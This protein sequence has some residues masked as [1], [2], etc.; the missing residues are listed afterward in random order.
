MVIF[1]QLKEYI[2]EHRI[3]SD[4]SMGTYYS[5]L[6]NQT[7]AV[8]EFANLS[9]PEIIEQIH[10]EY[11]QAGARI[12]RTNT[13]AANTVVLKE[14]ENRIR[15]I[16]EAGCK[17]AK[18][19]VG[20]FYDSMEPKERVWILGNIG[21]IPEE[22]DRKEKDILKEY[23]RICDIFIEE[24]LDG[25]HFETF[26]GLRYIEKLVPYIKERNQDMFILSSFSVDKNG[27]CAEGIGASRLLDMVS[28]IDGID[29][30]GLNCGVGSGHMVQI[31]K[32]LSIPENKII[33]IAPNAGYPEQMHNRMVFMDNARYFAENMRIIAQQG[34]DIIGSCCG[35]SPQYTKKL[36]EYI[37]LDEPARK[38][39]DQRRMEL[40]K[41]SPIKENDFI[42]KL[43]KNQKVIA[44]ELDPPYNAD[45]QKIMECAHKLKALGADVITIADSP[46]GRSRVDSVLM[47]VKIA[48]E[49]NIP[50]MPHICCRDRNM[51]SM[52]SVIL[53]AYIHGIRN[54]LLVTGDPIPGESRQS[55]TGVF[56]YNSIRLMNFVKEMNLEHFSTDSLSYGGAL[57]YNRG[58]IDKV[59]DRMKRKMEAGAGFFLTQPVY[60]EE[61]A[62]R[63]KE[64]KERVDTKIICG[65]MP[66]VSYRNASFIKNEITGIHI[67]DDILNRY[68]PD[69][70]K[71]E[72]E[73]VGAA[74][75]REVMEMVEPF[76]DGYYFMLPFNRVSL[77]DK[78]I[79]Y[80]FD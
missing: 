64:I 27:Y 6:V 24:K 3:I 48:Q 31:V 69:M 44:V 4:G 23:Q 14:N 7:G 17:I 5:N 2:K 47:G 52:R 46:M 62:K 80:R 28:E 35:T 32:N 49:A 10:L 25:I 66:L 29:G 40:P 70:S 13:F 30:C 8:S 36:T 58:N 43:H 42:A 78:I 19:A 72:A 71:E 51:I 41:E 77:M 33:Y 11:L 54:L 68:H 1:M 9:S 73:N 12:L 37:A 55:T 67:P 26:P 56:D 39:H 76:V 53:G 16:I 50:V 74:I 59:I 15:D 20:N 61:D 34:V 21:P 60:T 18:K 22:G 65:I 79:Y 63:I 45:V 75:A 38:I 57:N